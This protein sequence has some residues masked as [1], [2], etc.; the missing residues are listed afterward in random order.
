M[1]K[2]TIGWIQIIVGIIIP[3]IAISIMLFYI[4]KET[5]ISVFSDKNKLLN[6][7]P[8]V[9]DT[10]IPEIQDRVIPGFNGLSNDTKMILRY[11]DWNLQ[12]NLSNSINLVKLIS[13][14]TIIL[15]LILSIILILQGLANIADK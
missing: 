4:P 5:G 9:T 14:S 11:E 2:K 15:T 10:S 3:I 12:S 1:K 7:L 13:A 6:R 8:I